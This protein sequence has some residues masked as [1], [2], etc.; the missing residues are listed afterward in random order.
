ME[1]VIKKNKHLSIKMVVT[2][3]I[4]D[5]NDKDRTLITVEDKKRAKKLFKAWTVETNMTMAALKEGIKAKV[6]K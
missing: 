3:E 6:K 5:H 1:K 4:I 2:Y